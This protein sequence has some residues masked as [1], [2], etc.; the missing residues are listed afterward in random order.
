MPFFQ[1]RLSATGELQYSIMQKLTAA[2]R[3]L[4][5]GLPENEVDEYARLE[6]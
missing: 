1:Q 3:V 4:A 5:Y 6:D 2:V